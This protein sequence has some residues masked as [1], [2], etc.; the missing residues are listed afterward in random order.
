MKIT[1]AHH[2]RLRDIR[3]APTVKE[4]NL[5]NF[6]TANGTYIVTKNNTIFNSKKI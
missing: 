1:L 3:L 2:P 5:T 4:T 6:V